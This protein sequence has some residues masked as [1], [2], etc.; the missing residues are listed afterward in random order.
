MEEPLE[1]NAKQN[2]P[3]TKRINF[4]WFHF[5]EVSIVLKF[6]KTERIVAARSW[7]EEGILLMDSLLQDESYGDE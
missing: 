6:I 7:E 1:H 2:N 3:V 5:S 4:V